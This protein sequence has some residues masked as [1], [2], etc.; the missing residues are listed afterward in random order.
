MRIAIVLAAIFVHALAG[1][2]SEGAASKAGQSGL[3]D[4]PPP[5]AGVQYR[6]AS[7]LAPGQEIER[8]QLFVAPPEGLHVRADEVKFTSGS[9]HVLLFRTPYKELPTHTLRGVP[10]DGTKV[11]DCADGPGT[12]WD[13]NGVVAGSQSVDGDTILGTLPDGVAV[14]VAPGTVLLMNTHYLNASPEPLETDA[15]INLYTLP[16]EDVKIEAGV[17]FHYNFF[18]HVPAGGEASARMRCPIEH[19]ISILRLQSHMHRRGVGFAAHLVREGSEAME[20]IYST[21]HWEQV[22]AGELTPPLKVKAG[23]ALD[24]RCDYKNPGPHDVV[25]GSTTKDEMCVLIGPYYPWSPGIGNCLNESGFPAQTWIGSGAAT[26]SETLE[27]LGEAELFEDRF[28]CVVNSCAGAS[29]EVSNVV[30]CQMTKG[31]GACAEA[32]GAGGD[33]GGCMSAACAGEVVACQAAACD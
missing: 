30:R 11:H 6:M 29:T 26:C 19:D 16:P 7:T 28:R 5:G 31:Y 22:P 20:E 9:H 1:C 4:P 2:S 32:C 27:C 15:R 33:C 14:R 10:I 18:I 3:L 25:Q 21:T 13:V 24:S 8:C 23:D 17:L 12:D